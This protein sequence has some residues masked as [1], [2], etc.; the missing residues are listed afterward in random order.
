MNIQN[1]LKSAIIRLRPIEDMLGMYPGAIRRGVVPK[2]H[3]TETLVFLREELLKWGFTD[4]DGT[5]IE[6]PIKAPDPVVVIPVSETPA[7]RKEFNPPIISSSAEPLEP[8]GC[9]ELLPPETKKTIYT[10]DSIGLP[11]Y[12]TKSGGFEIKHRMEL[13]PGTRLTIEVQE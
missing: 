8:E 6:T 5:I 13:A 9:R 1:V 12:T 4:L 2:A 3:Y 10:F 7:R 11:Y